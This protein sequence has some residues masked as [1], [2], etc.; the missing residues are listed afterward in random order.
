[1][2]IF[3]NFYKKNPLLFSKKI[4]FSKFLCSIF[5][6]YRFLQKKKE[7]NTRKILISEQKSNPKKNTCEKNAIKN[8]SLEIFMV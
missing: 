3:Y 4:T 2:G 6:K 8:Q 7:R 1:M 5:F